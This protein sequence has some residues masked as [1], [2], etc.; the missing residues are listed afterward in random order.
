MPQK[1]SE[2]EVTNLN[3]E[4]HQKES[5]CF[6]SIK[7]ESP[8]DW[9][10]GG[11][12]FDDVAGKVMPKRRRNPDE[13]V[14][15]DSVCCFTESHFFSLNFHEFQRTVKIL[16]DNN[17]SDICEIGLEITSQIICFFSSREC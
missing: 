14:E 12:Y 11:R 4:D 5:L 8:Y 1:W 3:I 9:E 15:K 13:Q 7:D 16:L 6:C 2:I 10:S 17:T